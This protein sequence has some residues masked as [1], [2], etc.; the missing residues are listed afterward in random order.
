[1]SSNNPSLPQFIETCVEYIEAEGK[2]IL[3]P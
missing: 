2:E 1:M 3:Y